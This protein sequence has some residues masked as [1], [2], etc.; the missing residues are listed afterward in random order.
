MRDERIKDKFWCSDTEE[1]AD[2]RIADAVYRG[3]VITK[4]GN[5][6]KSISALWDE[7]VVNRQ[8]INKLY[9]RMGII[10]GGTSLV[11][12]LVVSLVLKSL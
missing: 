7:M 10:A 2:R 11:V 5:I 4:L 1:C 12:S 3:E 9:F 6:E 8:H